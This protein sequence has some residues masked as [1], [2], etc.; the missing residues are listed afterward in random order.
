M[1][2]TKTG[3]KVPEFDGEEKNFQKWWMR[4]Q[5]FAV[6]KG[7]R[8]SLEEPQSSYLPDS[9]QEFLGM[10]PTLEATKTFKKRLISNDIA[11]A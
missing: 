6:V 5:A 3:L 7:F 8:A 4:F 11:M 2:D 9:Q 10:D 1:T